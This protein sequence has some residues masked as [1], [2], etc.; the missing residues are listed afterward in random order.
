MGKI[1]G[2]LRRCRLYISYVDV[3]LLRVYLNSCNR[4]VKDT[5][6]HIEAAIQW[7]CTAQDAFQEDDGVARS[8]SFVYT[9]YFD[10]K[11]WI[12]SYP[13]TTGYI[14][15]TMMDCGKLFG[16]N[17]LYERALRMA[18]WECAVQMKSGAVQGGVVD[19]EA[20]PA[21]FNTGQVIFGWLRAYQ[22]TKHQKYIDAALRAGKFLVA[23][24]ADDGSWRRQLSAYAGG[25][26]MDYFSYNTRTAWALLALSQQVDPDG[27]LREAGIRNIDFSLTQQLENGWFKSNCLFDQSRPLLHTIA[28]CIRGILESGLILN[29]EKY[30]ERAK[31]AADALLSVQKEDGSLAGR[32]NEKWQSEVEWG[33]L[34]GDAQTSIIWGKLY[35]ITGNEKY[36]EAID[37]INTYLKKKQIMNRSNPN[38]YGGI[39][40]ADPIHG[41]YGKFEILNWAVKFFIDALLMECLLKG[42][43]DASQYDGPQS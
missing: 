14:I 36:L 43:I 6:I 17:D 8:Y 23:V 7:L 42:K 37:R 29:N 32:Y 22:E 11:G 35:R 41:D 33:C 38:I 30:I 26:G 31:T 20:S 13:E 24:Q 28:Y 40:G 9:P 10:K 15:P 21:V 4:T 12:A 5:R 1:A 19:Q 25:S 3:D 27:S 34:T 39:A 2:V 16:R 18:D